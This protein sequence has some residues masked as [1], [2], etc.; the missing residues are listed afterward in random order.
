M[1][2]PWVIIGVI[3]VLLFGGAMWYSRV[4]AAQSNEG[5]EILRYVKENTEAPVKLV[6]YSDFQCP[7]CASFQPVLEEV[8]NKYGDNLSF[9]YKHFPLPMH[10][11]A[12]PAAMAAEAAGQQGKFFEFHDLLFANQ[13]TWANSATPNTFFLQYA[14]QLGLDTQQ[15]RRQMKSSILRDKIRNGILEGQDLKIDHTP[16]FFLNGKLM[17]FQTYQEFIDQVA[18]A[19]DP[20]SVATSTGSSQA[21]SG[22]RFG[23]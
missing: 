11:L 8:M 3:V 12:I 21:G 10:P 6:E 23:L 22:V 7:A 14:E 18:F 16:S 17:D 20:T 19:I 15:F 1:K 9:E 13:E 5:V 4:S 2:N